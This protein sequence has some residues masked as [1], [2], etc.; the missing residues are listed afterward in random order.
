MKENE[1]ERGGD[2]NDDEK[3]GKKKEGEGS[4]KKQ[5]EE[6]EKQGG[7]RGYMLSAVK[8][9]SSSSSSSS[10]PALTEAATTAAAVAVHTYT[11]TASAA[12][13]SSSSSSSSLPS[14]S[15]ELAVRDA[16]AAASSRVHT[17]CGTA[18]KESDLFVLRW[19]TARLKLWDD[20]MR[21]F[22][23][24]E[25]ILEVGTYAGKEMIKYTAL[26]SA[27]ALLSAFAWPATL[28]K[29]ADVID[30]PYSV[31]QARAR[32]AGVLLA[33]V[34]CGEEEGVAGLAGGGGGGGGGG[35]EREMG[36]SGQT[37]VAG[38]RRNSGK[39]SSG[40]SGTNSGSNSSNPS[41]LSRLSGKDRADAAALMRDDP[42][43]ASVFNIARKYTG[44]RPVT[45]VGYDT[46]ATVVMSCLLE[47]ADRRDRARDAREKRR[48]AGGP[49]SSSSSS[50]SFS[51]SPF[52]TEY[53]GIVFDA[54]LLG[55]PVSSDQWSWRR[56]RA[57]CGGRLIN[58]YRPGD[59]LLA[60]VCRTLGEGMG[61]A[62]IS[63][64]AVEGVE[65]V[66][67]TE[68]GA[69]ARHVDYKPDTRKIIAAL[70]I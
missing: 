7:A 69:A 51:S 34:L 39:N 56:A 27:S 11:R 12:S 35:E 16:V 68:S 37:W 66:D 21:N 61:V 65:N 5:Q 2:D 8:T 31:L 26:A 62:G 32:K 70:G 53:E 44:R 9:S 28:V 41:F 45:L 18:C 43:V 14:S 47:L 33:D 24:Q 54:V 67:L 57:V 46:G 49:S 42:S 23:M 58:C 40:S 6:Q 30:N 55:A 48:K 52:T 29:L 10:S 4:D 15:K 25:A 13:S 38:K 20:A 36:S 50:S 63:A 3:E 64:V 60:F 22:V 19:E 1:N 17:I 59:W